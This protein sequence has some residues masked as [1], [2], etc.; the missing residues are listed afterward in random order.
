MNRIYSVVWNA[1]LGVLQVVSEQVRSCCGQP[2]RKRIRRS[3]KAAASHGASY[4]PEAELEQ[5]L[6]CASANAIGTTKAAAFTLIVGLTGVAGPVWAAGAGGDVSYKSGIYLG[7]AGNGYG[8]FAV[9]GLPP[10]APSDGNGGAG[11]T[12]GA[13]AGGSGGARGATSVNKDDGPLAGGDGANGEAPSLGNGPGGGGGGAGVYSTAISVSFE[14]TESVKGGNGGNGASVA[15]VLS[16]GS[17]G[18]GGAGLLMSSGAL[19]NSGTVTGGDGGAGGSSPYTS[20]EGGGGGGGGGG[21]DGVISTSGGLALTNSSSGSIH[22]GAGGAGGAGA[23]SSSNGGSGGGGDGVSMVQGSVINGGSI[24]GGSINSKNGVINGGNGGAALLVTGTTSTSVIYNLAGATIAGGDG[25]AAYSNMTPGSGGVGIKGMNLQITNAGTVSGGL[26]GD[27]TTRANA[28]E[29]TGGNNTLTLED[30]AQIR[31]GVDA[32]R[33]TNALILSGVANTNN[34]FNAGLLGFKAGASEQFVGFQRYSKTGVGRWALTGAT[35]E[36]TPWYVGGGTLSIGSDDSLGALAG[37]LTLNGATLQTTANLNSARQVVLQ[38][39]GTIQTDGA[40]QAVLNGQVTGDG[41][42]SKSGGGTLILN[43]HNTYGGSTRVLNGT[44]TVGDSSHLD[45]IVPGNLQVGLG[46]TL[47]GYGTVTGDVSSTGTVWPGSSI[48]QLSVS[49]NYSQAASATLRLD[50]SPSGASQLAV[51][52]SANLGGKLA[53]LYAPGT[54][55][56]TQYQL[57]SAAAITGNFDTIT[58]SGSVPQNLKQNVQVNGTGVVLALNDSDGPQ[59]QPEPE[60]EPEPQ[61]EPQPQPEPPPPTPVVLAPTNA[62]LFGALGSAAMREGQ[63]VNDVLL[64]RL[65]NVCHDTAS[66]GAG[67]NSTSNAANCQPLGRHAWVQA[68]GDVARVGGN[69]GAPGYTDR[70]YGFLAGVERQFNAWT[71]GVAGGYSHADVSEDQTGSSGTIDTLRIAAYGGRALG[72]V[73]LAGTFGYAHDFLTSSR[74]F[75]GFGDADGDSQGDEF[76][77][78]AQASLPLNLGRF[79][80][81]PRAGVRY[82]YFHGHAFDESGPTNQNLAVGMQNLKS[83][84]PYL[85]VTAAY[86]FLMMGERPGLVEV[87]LGYAYETLDPSRAVAVTAADGTGFVVPGTTS[88]RGMLSAGVGVKLPLRKALDLNA[89][90]DTLLH[91]GNVSGQAFRMSLSYRF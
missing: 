28:I 17:G 49:G 80:V 8:G 77:L 13:D 38:G 89:S 10:G 47:R 56:A 88:S 30:G 59:P 29:F 83:L 72:P 1:T 55:S 35:S 45:A 51:G 39:D 4:R 37:S 73:N 36:L 9:Y 41:G 86:P 24:S 26:N 20:D 61:P 48:G 66:V 12:S 85:G 7:G 40:T 65:S 74:N 53:L 62:T 78:A 23:G 58:A 25:G 91:T 71:A 81:T 82:Q 31:G 11:S 15:Y 34:T 67:S 5:R 2:G 27:G 52:G 6:P 46:A 70:R 90:Y 87:R 68:T 75:T 57:V 21:G 44:L 33:G 3:A 18:G 19:Y 22:G 63:R 16:P 79:V 64:E 42:L 69:H 14:N 60:P 84:Q 32:R 43:G 50:V 54:Y 76:H